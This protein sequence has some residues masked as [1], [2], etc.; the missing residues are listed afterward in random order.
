MQ[1]G[2]ASSAG[3][4]LFPLLFV[5]AWLLTYYQRA[6][7]AGRR[8][9]G[10]LPLL[11]KSWWLGPRALPI[12]S[13]QRSSTHSYTLALDEDVCS[14]EMGQSTLMLLEDGR[15]LPLPHCNSVKKIAAEG[16][17]RWVHV[18]RKLLF[19]PSD[20]A[21]LAITPHQ[22][23]LIDGLGGNPEIFG[24]LSKLAQVRAGF[25]NPA[26]YALAKL[27]LVLGKRLTIGT[28]AELDARRLRVDGLKLDLA[29]A[30]LPELSV[31][32]LSLDVS[33]AGE[34]SRIQADLA[35]VRWGG[36][37]LDELGLALEIDEA[38]Q[39][40]LVALNARRSGRTLV[41][42]D[43]ESR[44]GAWQSA[45]LAVSC[46]DVLRQEL[47]ACCGGAEAAADWLDGILSDLATGRLPM[48]V[49]LPEESR[50]SL[51]A[52]LVEDGASSVLHVDIIRSGPILNLAVRDH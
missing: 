42:L 7:K 18:E 51:R 26:A 37:E 15:P 27:K 45:R 4:P 49:N 14:D 36:I 3:R 28:Q 6:L 23:H 24:A 43:C 35:G 48:G 29:P 21:D 22:Y 17:G 1:T 47:A 25:R 16:R 39:P 41:D 30:H 10:A 8:D 2:R 44:D 40:R 52:A 13:L 9:R 34:A 33:T 11:L 31:N 50:A 20:N 38:Y 19:A 46:L 12:A 5:S 32:S